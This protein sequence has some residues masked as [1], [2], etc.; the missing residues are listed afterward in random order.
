[1]AEGPCAEDSV[2]VRWAA[3]ANLHPV[4]LMSN[5]PSVTSANPS[6]SPVFETQN[7]GTFF[8]CDV[9]AGWVIATMLVGTSGV[10]S[11]PGQ[12]HIQKPKPPLAKVGATGS[13]HVPKGCL[14][15]YVFLGPGV[16]IPL[17]QPINFTSDAILAQMTGGSQLCPWSLCRLLPPAVEAFPRRTRGRPGAC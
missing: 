16:H 14:G 5:P 12:E 1:M 9:E 8:F 11:P 13:P 10:A 4:S 6:R 3:K 15:F 2:V 17:R 7:A